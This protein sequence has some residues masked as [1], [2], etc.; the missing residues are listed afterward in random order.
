MGLLRL[1]LAIVLLWIGGVEVVPMNALDQRLGL[2]ISAAERCG[3]IGYGTS[4][5]YLLPIWVFA[6]STHLRSR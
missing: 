6:R 5:I 2:E 4:N 3:F 1:G